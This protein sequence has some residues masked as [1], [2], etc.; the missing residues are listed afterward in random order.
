[1]TLRTDVETVL[2]LS[3]FLNGA[4]EAALV[5]GVTLQFDA[6]TPSGFVQP[7]SCSCWGSNTLYPLILNRTVLG[8][9]QA[10]L[11]SYVGGSD[12][13]ENSTITEA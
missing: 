4:V 2:L 5:D 12:G 13:N 10:A 3:V 9:T 7:S 1:M 6:S 11:E 8:S